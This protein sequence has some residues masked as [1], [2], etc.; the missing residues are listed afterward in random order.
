MNNERKSFYPEDVGDEWNKL[1]LA[2]RGALKHIT[3]AETVVDEAA[4]PSFTPP[5]AVNEE[6]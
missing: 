5:A 1:P 3:A 2:T 6:E 4:K